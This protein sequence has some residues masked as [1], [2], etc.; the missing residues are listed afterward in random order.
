M[1]TQ[2]KRKCSSPTGEHRYLSRRRVG[3]GPWVQTCSW[4]GRP[5]PKQPK[6]TTQE[7]A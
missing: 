5:Q 6:P 2:P 3:D 7:P 1:R 4:C